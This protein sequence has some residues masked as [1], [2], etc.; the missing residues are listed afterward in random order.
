MSSHPPTF[1]QVSRRA[2]L[3]IG[4]QT[5]ARLR[6]QRAA[7]D[8]D[9][10]VRAGGKL[11]LIETLLAANMLKPSDALSQLDAVRFAWRGGD[12]EAR[13]LR[14]QLRIAA[15]SNDLAGQLRVQ[16]LVERNAH[17]MFVGGLVHRID[18]GRCREDSRV[19]PSW[20]SAPARARI[21]ML[22]SARPGSLV[23]LAPRATA[24]GGRGEIGIH[25]GLK[26]RRARAHAGSSPVARTRQR[27]RSMR[28]A[29]E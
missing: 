5:A 7:Q 15:A 20:P 18:G 28:L 19:W 4:D 24:L 8:S 13:A 17:G 12:I 11:G 3:A 6:F 1:V 23:A 16:R 9:P 27:R 26:I 25:N 2:L 10:E 14:E 22:E 29:F 21:R